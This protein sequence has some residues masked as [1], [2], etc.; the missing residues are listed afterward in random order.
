MTC[1]QMER[2]IAD[3][4]MR[5]RALEE[6]KRKGIWTSTSPEKK[7]REDALVDRYGEYV[8]KTVASKILG[9]TR[10]TVY[11][12]I[13]DGRIEAACGGKRVDVRSI[14]RYQ[15]SRTPPEHPRG[16]RTV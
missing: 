11:A 12:M 5:I 16:E 4:E 6:S 15:D 14:A 2:R 1:D 9:V 3:M 13:A 10:Q 8:D 7:T